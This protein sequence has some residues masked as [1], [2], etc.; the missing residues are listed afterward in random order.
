[1]ADHTLSNLVF[2]REMMRNEDMWK[3]IREEAVKELS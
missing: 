3:I 2:L 1:M